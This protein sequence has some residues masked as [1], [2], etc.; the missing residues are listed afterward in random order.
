MSLRRCAAYHESGHACVA[1]TLGHP[2]AWAWISDVAGRMSY[3]APLGERDQTI[4][5]L[6]GTIAQHR[7]EPHSPLGQSD[8]AR[9]AALP[10]DRYRAEAERLVTRHWSL[11][12]DVAAAL[13]DHGEVSG[14]EVEQLSRGMKAA[15]CS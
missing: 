1:V 2:V 7:A 3:A 10:V 15:W 9:L 12:E 13:L 14:F 6:A 5:L 8:A 11:I 4:I